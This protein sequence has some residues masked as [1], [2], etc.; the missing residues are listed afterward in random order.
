MGRVY[1][2]IVLVLCGASICASAHGGEGESV[3]STAAYVVNGAE[4]LLQRYA[5]VFVIE[6]DDLAFN[7]IGT[8]EA[9]RGT[10][11]KE[12][13]HVN[14]SRPT[15]YTE[16]EHFETPR[17]AYTNLIYRVH[18]KANPFTWLPLNVS[19]GKNVGAMAVITLNADDEPVWLSTVQSCGC[20]HAILPTDYLP[21]DAYPE[22]WA[23]TEQVVYGEHLPGQLSMK[24]RA[25]KDPR[26]VI[27]IRS[28]SHRCMGV[29][30]QSIDE[31][32]ASMV[33]VPAPAVPIESLKALPLEDGS[34]TSFYH[35]QGHSKGLVKGAYKPL[36]TLLFGVWSWD[37]N[38]GQDRE[39]G[40]KERAGRRFYTT[41]F[42]PRKKAADMWHYARY[43]EHNGWKP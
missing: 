22:G 38:V 23:H 3:H 17:G 20:Y 25:D 16:V 2:C 36:E 8:P 42:F 27:R 35:S 19:A 13:V 32:T 34:T 37:H 18:F 40:P 9:E 14:P 39:Y 28:S 10:R 21:D 24:E 15:V 5:P 11:G 4:G 33:T 31:V 43:L 29:T 7:K 1:R 6:N 30:L 26:M 12:K 41:L